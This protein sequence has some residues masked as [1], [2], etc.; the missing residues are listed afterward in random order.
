MEFLV[1]LISLFESND[2]HKFKI[3]QSKHIFTTTEFDVSKLKLGSYE[4]TLDAN[5]LV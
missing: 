2:I 1:N 4:E 3:Y 5:E